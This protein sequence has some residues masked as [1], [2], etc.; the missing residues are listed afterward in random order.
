MNKIV[1]KDVTF[2]YPDGTPALQNLSLSITGKKVAILGG[3]GS[4]KSTLL[5]HLN[6]LLSPQSG[7]V[8]I[9]GEQ[10]TKKTAKSIRKHVGLVFDQP[11]HQLIATAV[12][13]DIAFGP[14]NLGWPE[15]QVTECVERAMQLIAIDELRERIPYQLSLGQKK[16]VTIA[17]VLAMEPAIILFD[18]PFSGLDPQALEQ[19]LSSLDRL[20]A[21]GHTLIISTHDVDI[22]YGWA[23]ECVLLKK[24]R[25]VGQ[26][27]AFILSQQELVESAG[28]RLPM[29]AA[30]F[31]DR[32]VYPRTV[33]EA[34]ELLPEPSVEGV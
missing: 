3:N 30:I 5:Q 29:L 22:V 8:W 4:G 10:L 34:R 12:H 11:E 26:G 13:E 19:F 1:L 6:G 28:L 20:E 16:K 21:E 23:D 27:D 25:L 18:E 17:G 31:G 14:R 33:K 2:H 7:E 15:Q 24:G 32:G 9:N